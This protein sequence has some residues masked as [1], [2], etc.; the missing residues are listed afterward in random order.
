MTEETSSSENQLKSRLTKHRQGLAAGTAAIA[1]CAVIGSAAVFAGGTASNNNAASHVMPV[2]AIP[3]NQGQQALP[4]FADL[5]ER[6]KP[7]V[8][9]VYVKSEQ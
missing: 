1:I 4:S 5:V 9:S 3:A 6:V 8:V 2:A 7:A